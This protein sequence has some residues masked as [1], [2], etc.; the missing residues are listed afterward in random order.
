[1]SV[2]ATLLLA[3]FLAACGQ[4][5]TT[6]AD[7]TEREA[8]VSAQAL[9]NGALVC[10]YEDIN[11]QGASFCASQKSGW[12][13]GAWND[14]ISSFRLAGG[15]NILLYRDINYGGGALGV[16]SSIINLVD[17]GFNDV[18]SSFRICQNGV[19]CP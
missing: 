6:P 2:I 5:A 8:T 17:L 4:Q 18:G 16:D 15:Y 14:R 12:V 1:M 13:G 7:P 3:F 19:P 11:Y 10:F 9:P